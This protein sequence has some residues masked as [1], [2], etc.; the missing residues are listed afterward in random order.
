MSD[1]SHHIARLLEGVS[2]PGR[3]DEDNIH[4]LA[5]M[6]KSTK[7]D[8][9]FAH[10]L[11]RAQDHLNGRDPWDLANLRLDAW[12][13]KPWETTGQRTTSGAGIWNEK[14]DRFTAIRGRS[15]HGQSHDDYAGAKR[16]Y[17]FLKSN[18]RKT[19][20]LMDEYYLLNPHNQRPGLV[21]H[22]RL[23]L[24]PPSSPLSFS[25]ARFNL[26]FIC[27]RRTW[28]FAEYIKVV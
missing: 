13:S 14:R 5:C 1:T 8:E 3:S 17:R 12:L 27:C 28:Y 9:R 25:R 23:S 10:E 22:V 19:K 6:L 24:S 16:T 20:W 2:E 21:L 18:G 7:S 26:C 4:S 15:G 11:L